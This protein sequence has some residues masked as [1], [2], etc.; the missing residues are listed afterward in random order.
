MNRQVVTSAAIVALLSTAFSAGGTEDSPDLTTLKSL[1]IEE[2]MQVKIPTVY[3]ASKHEQKITEAPSSVTIVT[4]EEI[5][6]HAHRTLGDVL[7]SVRDFYV[8]YD[9]DY[10]HIGVRGLNRP[11]D[12]GGRILILVDGL[13]LND[14]IYDSAGVL[15]DFPV[16]VDLIERVEVIRGPGSALYGNN[17]FLAVVNVITRAGGDVNGVETSAEIGSLNTYKGRFTYGKDFK[18]GLSILLTGTIFDSAGNER[19]YFKE[20]DQPE[21][22]RGLAE[23]RDDDSFVSL[24][25]T[26]SYK[27]FTLQSGYLSRRKEVP[28]ASFGTIFNDP[29]FFTLDQRA[30]TRLGYAHEFADELS[31]RANLQWNSYY[32]KGDYPFAAGKGEPAIINR[33]ILNA[34]WWGA[35][36]QVAKELFKVH[37]L[38]LGMEFQDNANQKL[39]N[40]DVSPRA[41]YLNLEAATSV[42]GLYLQD[43][44]AITKRLTLNAGLRYDWF[45]TFGSTINPRGALV[46]HPFEKTTL[47]ALYGQAYRAPNMFEYSYAVAAFGFRTNPNL[48]PEKVKSYELVLEQTLTEQWR[49]NASGFY[50][51]IDGLISEREDPANGERFFEN[52]GLAE[53][54]GASLELEATL[55]MG[56]KGRTSYTLQRQ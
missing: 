18:S 12:F 3:G 4:R 8:T 50:N 55:P 44:W 17:A 35:D 9:R 29:H 46:W 23:G 6:I 22:N 51:R 25:L 19:L 32:Y 10:G 56:F 39:V 21:N 2:I 14:P 31:I 7:N 11:G 28:T 45:E 16:D 49:L 37:R 20:F 1:S 30:F 42:I 33:D 15:T 13:R 40:Y 52:G 5:Q 54:K 41:D 36:I 43:E 24:G 34:Q 53:T 47:K 48:Q 26:F 27:D 38:A